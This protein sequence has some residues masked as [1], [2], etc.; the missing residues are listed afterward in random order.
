MRERL[1]DLGIWIVREPRQVA[2]VVIGAWS[3]ATIVA[4][5]WLWRQAK[6]DTAPKAPGH[7][8]RRVG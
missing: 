1:V 3:V 8:S 4:G 5:L 6:R 2:A 7:P